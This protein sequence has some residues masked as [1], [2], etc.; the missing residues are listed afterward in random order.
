MDVYLIDAATFLL[1]ILT[2]VGRWNLIHADPRVDNIPPVIRLNLF[3][4]TPPNAVWQCALS[5]RIRLFRTAVT[6]DLDPPMR[7]IEP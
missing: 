5:E 4:P 2:P 7:A 3:P 1:E 6:D